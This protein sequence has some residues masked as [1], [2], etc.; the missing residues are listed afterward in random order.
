M[1]EDGF[2]DARL[3]TELLEL[4][5]WLEGEGFGA[6]ATVA[7]ILRFVAWPE[8][9]V[10]RV[11]DRLIDRGDVALRGDA[12]ALTDIGRGD[13]RR[14]FADDFADLMKHGHGECDDP[15]CDCHDNPLGAADCR[16]RHV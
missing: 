12:Y 16:G 1:S 13:A 2:G 4:L 15:D 11:L 7:G 3:H 9:D 8:A 5:Y 10:R 14:R 6:D